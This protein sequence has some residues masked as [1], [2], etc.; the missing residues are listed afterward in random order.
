MLIEAPC[1]LGEWFTHHRTIGA[2]ARKQML[3]GVDLFVWNCGIDGVTL[4]GE[5]TRGATA[6]FFAREDLDERKISI[7]VPDAWAEG[8]CQ[9]E[10]L[11]MDPGKRWRLCGV[12]LVGDRGWAY[13]LHDNSRRENKM[14]RTAPLDKLFAPLLPARQVDLVDFL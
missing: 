5:W 11:G 8:S 1:R 4:L 6:C 12:R 3:I 7:E 13:L 10:E 2:P 9:P 14:V